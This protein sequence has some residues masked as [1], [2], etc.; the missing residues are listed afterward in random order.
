MEL[1][2]FNYY[3]ILWSDSSSQRWT[4]KRQG[5]Q[6]N[7]LHIIIQG[8]TGVETTKSTGG[9][10]TTTK[11]TGGNCHDTNPINCANWK[12]LGHCTLN[13]RYRYYMQRNCCRSCRKFLKIFF[14]DCILVYLL[15]PN[16]C[17][18]I[19]ISIQINNRLRCM[20][21]FRKCLF[22]KGILP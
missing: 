5:I 21:F 10:V 13:H 16:L 22:F 8:N 9:S 15:N 1:P 7:F 4:V 19:I 3:I 12:Q 2:I 17:I 14:I 20:N 6:L 18:V 11:S